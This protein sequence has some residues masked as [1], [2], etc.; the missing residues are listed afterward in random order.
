MSG[1]GVDYLAAGGAVTCT[2]GRAFVGDSFFS[3]ASVLVTVSI[4]V[5]VVAAF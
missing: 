5:E 2:S 3:E 1:V 4:E